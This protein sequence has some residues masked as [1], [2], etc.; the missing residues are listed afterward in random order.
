MGDLLR[1]FSNNP[2]DSLL[3]V[4]LEETDLNKIVNETTADGGADYLSLFEAIFKRYNTGKPLALWF[5]KP[6]RPKMAATTSDADAITILRNEQ[7]NAFRHSGKI[8]EIRAQNLK[9]KPR[10]EV[11]EKTATIT[12]GLFTPYKQ[13]VID[14]LTSE[15]KLQ[16]FETYDNQE[17]RNALVAADSVLSLALNKSD[18]NSPTPTDT[19]GIDAFVATKT[20]YVSPL[21]SLLLLD[22]A[23]MRTGYIGY[24]IEKDKKKLK[25]YLAR[26]D[27]LQCFPPNTRFMFSNGVPNDAGY[28]FYHLYAI[29]RPNQGSALIN[30]GIIKSAEPNFT[31]TSQTPSVSVEMN[32]LG[33]QL[34][35]DLTARNINRF[36]AVV[37]D[38][39]VFSCPRVENAISGSFTEISG[40]FTVQ[41]TIDFAN[42]LKSGTLKAPMRVVKKY[43]SE[44]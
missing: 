34:W 24:T 41:Q 18:K 25:E 2:D 11:D 6:S 30:G 16:F 15:G 27:V 9:N 8:M 19:S 39:R 31:A 29:K 26:K 10:V 37:F 4:I 33:T 36:I 14:Y 3:N 21:F 22:N 35:H 23:D 28:V 17:M 32:A 44:D 5:V 12:I 42:I 13:D 7:A 1:N 20:E 40:G 38:N 43:S